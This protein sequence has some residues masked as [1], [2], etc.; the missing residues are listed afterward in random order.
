[1]PNIKAKSIIEFESSAFIRGLRSELV[2]HGRVKVREL[3]Y[4]TLKR[5]KGRQG[6]NIAKKKMTRYPKY[7][8]IVFTPSLKFKNTIQRWNGK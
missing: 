7:N 2:K 3:G 1:M 4:F 6:Y 5:M 8:K